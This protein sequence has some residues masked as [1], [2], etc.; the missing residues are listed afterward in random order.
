MGNT[1]GLSDDDMLILYADW[2]MWL[3][4]QKTRFEAQHEKM[5]RK[6]Q[7]KRA[8]A[9]SYGDGSPGALSSAPAEALEQDPEESEDD[10]EVEE[11]A[12]VLEADLEPE[13]SEAAQ[14]PDQDEP[15]WL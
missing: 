4:E 15:A 3:K 13:E 1:I 11:A 10:P 12:P 5:R 7:G 8:P 14:E 2:L 6:A 9:A